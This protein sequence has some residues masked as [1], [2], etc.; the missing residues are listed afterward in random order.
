MVVYC[1][2]PE[3]QSATMSLVASLAR[4]V[5][6]ETIL[7]SFVDVGAPRAERTAAFRRLL[8][9]RAEVRATHGLDLRTELQTG[10]TAGQMRRLLAGPEPALL[11]IGTAGA[12]GELETTLA[13]DFNWLF[14]PTSAVPAFVVHSSPRVPLA[15]AL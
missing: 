12:P 1:P 4:N 6:A 7:V 10:D 8:D 3:A 11:I 9:A 2:D 13:R 14:A 15:A 5:P